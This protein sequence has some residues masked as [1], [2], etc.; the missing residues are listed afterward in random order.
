VTGC[1]GITV[2]YAGNGTFTINNG[3]GGAIRVNQVL[4]TW[5]GSN[6]SLT[7]FKLKNEVD[8][9]TGNQPAPSGNFDVSAEP[10]GLRQINEGASTEIL[11][12]FSNP[13]AASGYSISLTFDVGCV[14][15]SAG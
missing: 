5:P 6:G 3:Y 11:F 10:P 9:W 2:G 14:K 13:P 4:L 15:N 7:A 8:A 1:A 12:T